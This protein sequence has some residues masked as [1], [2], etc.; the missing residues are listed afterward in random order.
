MKL[1][2]TPSDVMAV[3]LRD[4]LRID[5]LGRFAVRRNGESVAL[6]AFGGRLAQRLVRILACRRGELVTR[7]YLIEAL[8]GDVAPADPAS[9]LNVLVNRARRALGNQVAI[10]TASGGYLFAGSQEVRT[11]VELF[12]AAVAAAREAQRQRRWVA[13]LAATREALGLWRG[14]PL[15]EDMYDEWARPFRERLEL[16]HQELLEIGA[17]AAIMTG[18]LGPAADWAAQ[19]VALQPLREAAAIVRIRA[20]AAAGDNAAALKAY[21]VYRTRLADELGI[22]P[23]PAAA[24]FHQRL[25]RAET[26]PSATA[27][28]TGPGPEPVRFVGRADAQDSLKSL[29]PGAS[30]L[31][32]GVAGAGK[33]RL[34]HEVVASAHPRHVFAR[35]V[36]PEQDTPWALA[37]SLLRSA[38]EMGADPA[39]LAPMHR[40]SLVELLPELHQAGGEEGLEARSRRALS[41]DAARRLFGMVTRSAVV[42]DDLQWAD[43][44]SL[45][46]LRLLVGHTGSDRWMFAWR[47]ELGLAGPEVRSFVGW[48]RQRSGTREVLLSP[49]QAADVALLVDDAKVAE[50]LAGQTDG[51]P[52]AV[53]AVLQALE[54][55]QVVRRD[56]GGWSVTQSRAVKRASAAAAAGR[57]RSILARLDQQTAD[58]RELLHLLATLDRPAETGLLMRATGR[59][60]AEAVLS[61]LSDTSLVRLDPEGWRL[62]HDLVAETIRDGLTSTERARCHQMLARALDGQP[63]TRSELARHLAGAGDTPGAIAAYEEAARAQLEHYADREAVRASDAGLALRPSGPARSALLAVKGEARARLGERA[64]ARSDLREALALT[65]DPNARART[66]THLAMLAS[67]AEDMVRADHLVELAL[68]EPTTSLAARARALSVAAIVDMN[69]DRPA[70]AEERYTDAL[71]LYQRAGDSRGVADILDARA[72]HTFLSGHIHEAVDAFDNVATIFADLGNLLRGLSPRSLRGHALVFAARPVEGLIDIE[73]SLELSR[74][75]GDREAHSFALMHKTDALVALGRLDE[76][77]SAASESLGVATQI[78][79][80]GLTTTAYRA[81]GRVCRARGDLDG[82]HEAF[83]AA[84]DRSAHFPL[85]RSWAL[86]GLA[87]VETAQ[88]RWTSAAAHVHE[89]LEIGP[90]LGHFDAREANCELAAARGDDDT[91]PLVEEALRLAEAEGYLDSS[92]RLRSLL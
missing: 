83:L 11:D 82:A 47:A 73:Q 77:S 66:L 25:L 1:G 3:T 57:R 13:A 53:L 29:L 23:S 72:M 12:D 64:A 8:W 71:A 44:S 31:V 37:R 2:P 27:S 9:N 33:S 49:W 86:S 28:E 60:D 48:L 89:A 68:A 85:F 74:S 10:Q 43:A 54:R 67:G 91:A 34:L 50:V 35:A 70:R 78:G 16:V 52:F 76:A 51:T 32:S 81:C 88:G 36:Q 87:L 4:D 75:L 92:P 63:G 20:L 80:R 22:D 21:D 39:R 15:P 58:R 90:P 38:I 26:V 5:V 40:A 61:S 84:L 62:V 55:E 19:A 7:D 17:E 30:G 69:L 24:Q 65:T 56:T 59:H 14:D 18:E 41:L 79:H 46:L 6:S 42:V 45:E